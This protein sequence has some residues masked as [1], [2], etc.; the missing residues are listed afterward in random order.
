MR[1]E[2][3][4]LGIKITVTLTVLRTGESKGFRLYSKRGWY[5]SICIHVCTVGPQG[6]S[7]MS[8]TRF[9]HQFYCYNL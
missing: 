7:L 5:V 9:D 2:S 4:A 3:E 6:Q 1:D 8:L